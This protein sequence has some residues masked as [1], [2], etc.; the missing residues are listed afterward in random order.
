MPVIGDQ[1]RLGTDSAHRRLA[2]AR[3][4]DSLIRTEMFE[5]VLIPSPLQR[6]GIVPF[7]RCNIATAGPHAQTDFPRLPTALPDLHFSTRRKQ[8]TGETRTDT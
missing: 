2:P 4:G 3:A 7:A 6:R 8:E 1:F 5:R